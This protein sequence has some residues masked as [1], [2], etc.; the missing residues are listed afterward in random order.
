MCLGRSMVQNRC[1][2]N[3]G[4]CCVCGCWCCSHSP[5][6]SLKGFVFKQGTFHS[7]DMR[8]TGYLR[9]AISSSWERSGGFLLEVTSKLSL[10]GWVVLLLREKR[11]GLSRLVQSQESQ[12]ELSTGGWENSHQIESSGLLHGLS[13]PHQATLTLRSPQ[14]PF[15]S[16]CENPLIIIHHAWRACRLPLDER[17][18]YHIN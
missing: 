2:V 14:T 10:E 3:N 7:C 15:F 6:P 13:D 11:R 4:G 8:Y 18:H 17:K 9:I 1:S 12:W 16:T 5:A